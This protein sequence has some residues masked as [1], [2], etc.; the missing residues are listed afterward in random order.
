MDNK[1]VDHITSFVSYLRS[2]KKYSEHTITGYQSD[3]RQYTTYTMDEYGVEAV[4]VSHIQIRS[5]VVA[6][7]EEGLTEK[8]INR[9]ISTLRSFYN[10]L[11][12]QQLVSTNP[13]AKIVGPK[14][15]KRLPQ[16]VDKDKISLVLDDKPLLDMD[17]AAAREFLI[18][19]LLYHTGM[20]RGELIG[21][22][23]SDIDFQS[24]VIKV[25]GKGNKERLIPLS[26]IIVKELKEYLI[27]R[28]E[29]ATY[30][31]LALILTE[32]GKPAYPKLIYNVV[33]RVLRK[34]NASEKV[35]PHVL[36]HTFATHLTAAGADLNAIKE[37]LGH[38]SLAATQVYTHNSVERLKEIYDKAHPKSKTE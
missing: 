22:K 32:K 33:S 4:S 1:E 8:S 15:P 38:S 24:S 12:R 2:V 11:K 25:L 10:Y 7:I 19:S 28:E 18:I 30:G 13:M 36:R 3:L 31:V 29:I 16:Y 34:Y 26:P 20:R 37:L 21:L 14:V 6:L 27:A 17:Y 23:V 5:W 35:G 9:K